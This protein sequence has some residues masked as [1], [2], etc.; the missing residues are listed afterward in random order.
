[1]R[2]AAHHQLLG[3]RAAASEQA[4]SAGQVIY[5]SP[6]L[7]GVLRVVVGGRRACWREKIEVFFA[8]ECRGR[9]TG[10]GVQVEAK[11]WEPGGEI[12]RGVNEEDWVVKGWERMWRDQIHRDA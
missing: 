10:G 4:I 8:V 11:W 6:C 9:E 7:G 2:L 1:M 12:G 5:C 3:L